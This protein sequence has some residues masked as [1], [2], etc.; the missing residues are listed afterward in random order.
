MRRALHD[1]EINRVVRF[2]VS[3]GLPRSYS[4][5]AQVLRFVIYG[6]ENTASRH[7][8]TVQIISNEIDR[9]EAPG[10]I[11]RYYN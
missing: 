10:P 11:L 1:G 7:N 5:A 3:R 9:S 4:I 8:R 2:A 6:N